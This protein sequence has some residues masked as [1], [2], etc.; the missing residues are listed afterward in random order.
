MS[1]NHLGREE[2][3][4]P[5]APGPGTARPAGAPAYYLGRPASAWIAAARRRRSAPAASIAAG[6]DGASRLV[7]ISPPARRSAA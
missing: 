1:A 2:A 6:P 7:R 3:M 5:M 4:N